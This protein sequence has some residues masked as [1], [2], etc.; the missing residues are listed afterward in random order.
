MPHLSIDD[1]HSFRENGYLLVNDALT[2]RQVEAAADVLWDDMALDREDPA[3]WINAG[4]IRMSCASHTDIRATLFDSPL[5]EMA[6]E[7]VG[8]G[9]IANSSPGPHMVYPTG[10]K[11]W[12]PPSGGH[13]DGYYTPTNGVPEG[14]VGKFF[15]GITCYVNHVKPESGGFTLWPG[16]HKQTEEYFKSH[17][18]L[19]VQGGGSRDVFDLPASIEITGPP[20]TAVIWHGRLMHSGSQNCGE[21]IRMA[22]ISRL[23]PKNMN[24]ILFETPDDMWQYWE[25]VS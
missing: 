6:E 16:T 22:L 25:G 13:L 14:T 8:Q 11:N 12:E 20:G 10:K 18:I 19:S 2:E 15:L 7:L 1:K 21:E 4:P 3:S 23:K 24:D 9:R 5:F 17:S